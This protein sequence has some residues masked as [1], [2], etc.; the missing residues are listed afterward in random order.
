MTYARAGSLAAKAE[1]AKLDEA[2]T[3]KRE[4]KKARAKDKSKL[5]KVQ[6]SLRHD[7]HDCAAFISP[8]LLL[9]RR[10]LCTLKKT[11]LEW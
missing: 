8:A 3:A 5:C 6:Y 1:Q 2:E 10:R 9:F 4:A 11:A 7:L